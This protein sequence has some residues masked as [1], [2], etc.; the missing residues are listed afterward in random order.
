VSSVFFNGELTSMENVPAQSMYR[1]WALGDGVFETIRFFGA[2]PLLLDH[3]FNRLQ[4]GCSVLQLTCPFGSVNE[5]FTYGQRLAEYM[6]F[7]AGVLRLSLWRKGEG[8]Y[9]SNEKSAGWLLQIKKTDTLL[10]P[11]LPGIKA[12]LTE[13]NLEWG[14]PVSGFKTSSSLSYVLGAISQEKAL[15]VYY[16]S[17]GMLTESVSDCLIVHHKSEG[18]ILVDNPSVGVAGCLRLGYESLLKEKEIPYQVRTF[19]KDEIESIRHLWLANAVHGLRWIRLLGSNPLE[20]GPIEWH[21]DLLRKY[22]LSS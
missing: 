3:H 12:R 9:Y 5:L 13:W 20:P 17:E 16:N 19:N 8:A 4:K 22:V 2:K 18:I 15:P 1:L 6:Q 10:Y 7:E 14:I 21:A 11:I